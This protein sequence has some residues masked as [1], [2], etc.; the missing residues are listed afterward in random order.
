MLY[1][2]CIMIFQS[3]TCWKFIS[4]HNTLN[5]CVAEKEFSSSNSLIFFNIFLTRKWS[6]HA[7]WVY[8]WVFPSVGAPWLPLPFVYGSVMCSSHSR[9][10]WLICFLT[11]LE[12]RKY[13]CRD[14][15]R[16]PRGTLYP[17][18]LSLTSPSSGFRSV[19]IVHSRTQA[20]EL[21][22]CFCLICFLMK[23][24]SEFS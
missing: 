17:Q 20:T 1:G 10:C 6:E 3:K 14:P 13:G 19:G 5:I 18:K 16:W 8:R 15:S 4:E 2:L 7:Q 11:G 22:F 12:I 23:V 21:V 24:C 9:L